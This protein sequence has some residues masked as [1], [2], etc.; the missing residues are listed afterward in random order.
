MISQL[1]AVIVDHLL[2]TPHTWCSH[3]KQASISFLWQPINIPNCSLELWRIG[4]QSR[5]PCRPGRILGDYLPKWIFYFGLL[6]G[7]V[8]ERLI[9][10]IAQT[11]LDLSDMGFRS[12]VSV[13]IATIPCTRLASLVRPHSR[14]YLLTAHTHTHTSFSRI[15]IIFFAHKFLADIWY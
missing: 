14:E 9:T 5:I 15:P 11:D 3:R 13:I 1:S 6:K 4:L 10:Q 12:T 8:G 7:A 2:H